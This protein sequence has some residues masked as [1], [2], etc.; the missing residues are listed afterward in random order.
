MDNDTAIPVLIEGDETVPM[1][2]I[3]MQ[4][5]VLGVR[6]SCGCLESRHE[7]LGEGACVYCVDCPAFARAC[8]HC[9]TVHV[10]EDDDGGL[11]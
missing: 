6:C 8:S 3:T 9:G 5:L 1:A 2:P 7:L 10:P 4:E 11:S